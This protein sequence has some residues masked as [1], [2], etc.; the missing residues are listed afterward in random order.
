MTED[1]PTYEELLAKFN[2][3]KE[4]NQKMEAKLEETAN[5]LNESRAL[6]TKLLLKDGVTPTPEPDPEPE[7]E[8]E[9]VEQFVDSFIKKSCEKRNKDYGEIIYDVN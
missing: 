4:S 2:E 6:N 9:T 7:P 1:A 8:P 3:L 5:S